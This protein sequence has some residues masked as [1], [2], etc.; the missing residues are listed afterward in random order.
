[1]KDHKR[2]VGMLQLQST[3]PSLPVPSL[4]ETLRRY[5]ESVK[6]L[7]TETEFAATQR[8]VEEFMQPD[9]V[10]DSLQALLEKRAEV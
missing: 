8:A 3:L 1:M 9:G 4:Q 2:R 6:A 5:L 7:S 10:G